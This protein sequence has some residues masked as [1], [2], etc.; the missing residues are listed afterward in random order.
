M[1]KSSSSNQKDP[2]FQ[3]ITLHRKE[4]SANR[5]D[6]FQDYLCHTKLDLCKVFVYFEPFQRVMF[7]F[8]K[9]LVPSPVRV[10]PG[11]PLPIDLATF[12]VFD[13]FIDT[14]QQ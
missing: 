6:T 12:S 4:I 2:R 5:H 9:T 10:D 3:I 7:R 11:P 1:N 8:Q 13:V 14:K